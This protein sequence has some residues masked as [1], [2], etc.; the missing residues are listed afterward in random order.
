MNFEDFIESGEVKTYL[1]DKNLAVALIKDSLERADFVRRLVSREENPKYI[2]ENIYDALRELIEAK[3]AVDGFKSYSHEATIL[4]LK[5]FKEFTDSEIEF[6]DEL[7]KIR[8]KI[9]YRGENVNKEESDK[10]IIF[11]G[12][13]LPKLRT[14]VG[15]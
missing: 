15:K 14:L 4:Y 10:A 6:L 7:R 3:L 5:K 13:I 2:I 12:N 8:N 9:K 11:M 1:I